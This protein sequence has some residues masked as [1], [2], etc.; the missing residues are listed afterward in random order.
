MN[1]FND[2]VKYCCMDKKNKYTISKHK[3]QKTKKRRCTVS[4]F[5]ICAH[6]INN[7][8][9]ITLL[10]KLYFN[11]RYYDQYFMYLTDHFILTNLLPL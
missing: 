4:Y 5:M 7:N 9:Y 10:H 6:H 11:V 1:T 3:K 8:M 2:S